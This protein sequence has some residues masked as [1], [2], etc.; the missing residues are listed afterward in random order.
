MKMFPS[1][2]LVALCPTENYFAVAYNSNTIEIFS[3]KDP[4]E[5]LNTIKCEKIK[6]VEWKSI[7]YS[8]DGKMLMITTNSSLIKIVNLET[9]NELCNF[10]GKVKKTRNCECH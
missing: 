2:P 5:V 3:I 6:D 1:T 7:K 4:D 9:S 8:S 10:T